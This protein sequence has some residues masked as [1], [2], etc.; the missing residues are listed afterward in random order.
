VSSEP[1]VGERGEFG[2][3]A[4]V[5][6]R[7]GQGAGV[8]LGPG[9]DA[10]LV[11]APDGRVVATTDLLVEGRHFRRD[12]S[13]AADVGHK[14]AA[15]NL[16]DIVAMGA[17]PTAVLIGLGTPADLPVEWV[18]ELANGLR[19]EC[20]LV[21]ASVVGGDVVRSDMVI[22]SGM[23]LGDLEGRPPVTR[24]GAEAGDVVAVAGRLGWAAG[25]LAVLQRGFR[26][27]RV[28]VEAHRRPLPPY[29]LGPA[30]ARAG[31]SAMC[32]V[33]DGLLADLGH[34]AKA[35]GVVMDLDP[36]A[37][38]VAAPLHDAGAAMGIDPMAWVLGGGEDHA[39]AATFPPSA[40]LPEGFV[41]VGR[42]VSAAAGGGAVLVDGAPWPGP[43]GWDHFA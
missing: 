23:A 18:L 38:T 19:E 42:V 33:S 14:A 41:V 24:A 21:G 39:L 9:D 2:L 5:T 11:A 25:G 1:T 36:A 10:A 17:R 28:L 7:L 8:L 16:A 27:P 4:D 6:A 3:V 35:S 15:Q 13:S 32:D 40:V 12:W 31:A 37:F 26:M 29:A 30:A 20:D 34:V 43:T 22:V